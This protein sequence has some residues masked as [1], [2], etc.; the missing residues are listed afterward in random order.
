MTRITFEMTAQQAGRFAQLMVLRPLMHH[1][2]D[3]SGPVGIK[4][5]P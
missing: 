5:R 1:P 4:R 3:V 2:G